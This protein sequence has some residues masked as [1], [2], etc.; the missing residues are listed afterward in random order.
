M[1]KR[2]DSIDIADSVKF[3]SRQRMGD[4]SSVTQ[5]TFTGDI[6]GVNES[7]GESVT[8]NNFD[9]CIHNDFFLCNRITF[10]LLC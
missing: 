6:G 7:R 3:S 2:K 4:M 1:N 9:F 10:D 8:F 5:A